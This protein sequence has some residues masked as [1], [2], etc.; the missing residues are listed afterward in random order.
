MVSTETDATGASTPADL[1]VDPATLQEKT[2]TC[3]ANQPG[4]ENEDEKKV[5]GYQVQSEAASI[6]NE[7]A[8]SQSE[9]ENAQN[10]A[11]SADIKVPLSGSINTN[12]LFGSNT[13]V[14]NSAMGAEIDEKDLYSAQTDPYIAHDKMG[15]TMNQPLCHN[16]QMAE[17]ISQEKREKNGIEANTEVFSSALAVNNNRN[18]CD[19][20][21]SQL[22][23]NNF[24]MAKDT[25]QYV[26]HALENAA[27]KESSLLS[28][29]NGVSPFDESG[30]LPDNSA[31]LNSSNMLSSAYVFDSSVSV[32]DSRPNNDYITQNA[33]LQKQQQH[34][35]A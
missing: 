2:F 20:S 13:Q 33:F 8:S 35:A 12:S 30:L 29:S 4:D 25:T 7:A 5:I 14:S 17:G 9:A 32:L 19:K 23:E 10:E 22:L 24:S 6:Q 27:Q 34:I 11:M 1:Y 3:P 15:Q 31:M 28:L 16:G 18:E 21:A 26:P